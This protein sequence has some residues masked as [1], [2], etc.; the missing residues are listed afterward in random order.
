MVKEFLNNEFMPHGHCYYWQPDI[1]W[2][3]VISDGLIALAY[4][5]IPITLLYF[6]VRRGTIQYWWLVTMFAAFILLCGTTHIFGI[7]TVWNPIYPLEGGVKAATA[8]ISML[9]AVALVPL[10]PR[11]LAMRTPEEL[12]QINTKLQDEIE[13]RQQAQN[14]LAA[15]VRRLEQSNLELEQFAYA[16]SHDLQAPLRSVVSFTQLAEKELAGQLSGNVKEYF[17]YIKTGGK[18]MQ[19]LVGD[20]LTMSRIDASDEAFTA[21]STQEAMAAVCGQLHSDVADSGAVIEYQNLPMVH[22]DAV[23]IRQLFQNLIGNGIKFQEQGS[24]PRVEIQAQPDDGCWHFIVSDNGIG[25]AA[26]H[27]NK[28]FTVFKRLHTKEQYEGTGMGLAICRKIVV[29]HGGRIWIESEP[30]AG[31]QVHFTLPDVRE[32][33]ETD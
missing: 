15:T 18:Q 22:G 7:I 33:A 1:L 13:L 23:Q 2:T 5:S 24:M 30:G 32:A 11:M 6:L 12:E 28:L 25:I 19:D 3:H 21:V 9:T 27:M 8:A 20:L 31:T 29:R 17:E 26:E 4:Y 10:V 14:E 16:A